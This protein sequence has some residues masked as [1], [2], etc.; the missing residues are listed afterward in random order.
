MDSIWI[1]ARSFRLDPNALQM[2]NIVKYCE[3]E[4]ERGKAQIMIVEVMGYWYNL[5]TLNYDEVSLCLTAQ[6]MENSQSS[7]LS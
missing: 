3:R 6:I 7:S 5:L 1:S 4:R 2:G